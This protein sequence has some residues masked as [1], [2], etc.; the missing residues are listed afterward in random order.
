MDLPESWLLLFQGQRQLLA[1]P[2]S[3]DEG[4]MALWSLWWL[5]EGGDGLRDSENA[6]GKAKE[7]VSHCV[8]ALSLQQLS[9]EVCAL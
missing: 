6:K 4:S 2:S 8:F 5:G 7:Q 9:T 1:A 3:T